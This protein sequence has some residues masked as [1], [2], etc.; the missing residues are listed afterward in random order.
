MSSIDVD[1]AAIDERELA[2]DNAHECPI[3]ECHAILYDDFHEDVHVVHNHEE[4]LPA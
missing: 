3:D 1:A 2:E 4:E